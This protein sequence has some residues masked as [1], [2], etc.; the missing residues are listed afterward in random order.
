MSQGVPE[1]KWVYVNKVPDKSHSLALFFGIS[2][3]CCRMEVAALC[4]VCMWLSIDFFVLYPNPDGSSSVEREASK[5]AECFLLLDEN[6]KQ[7]LMQKTDNGDVLVGPAME[8][9]W[10][11]SVTFFCC[12][13][14][15]CE[16]S[17]KYCIICQS[18]H[19]CSHRLDSVRQ[20]ANLKQDYIWQLINEWKVLFISSC[21]LGIMRAR[22]EQNIISITSDFHACRNKHRD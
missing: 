10:F 14:S 13:T 9:S 12:Q 4:L 7:K 3:S 5:A 17:Q 18:G 19:L 1:C 22:L 21:L 11:V 8:V 2:H 6:I 15:D 16:V 20:Q